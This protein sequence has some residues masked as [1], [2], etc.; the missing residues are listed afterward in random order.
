MGSDYIRGGP[1]GGA[2]GLVSSQEEE[3]G[4]LCRTFSLWTVRTLPLG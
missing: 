1:E 2:V 3:H 4:A